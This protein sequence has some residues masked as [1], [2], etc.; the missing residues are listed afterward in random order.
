M[1]NLNSRQKDLIKIMI[2]EA[3]YKTMKYYSAYIKVSPRTLFS[4]VEIINNYLKDFNLLVEKKPRVGIKLIGDIES[5]LKVIEDLNNNFKSTKA[6]S[7]E[8]RQLEIL[9]M[10]LVEEK[11]ISYQKLSEYFWVSKTSISKDIESIESLFNDKTIAI[12]SDKKGTRIIGSEVQKQ[13]SL[14]LYTEDLLNKKSVE[15]EKDFLKYAP[16]ILKQIYP[17]ELVN[18]IF[19]EVANLEKTLNISLTYYYLRSLI[20]TLII[21]I[22][23]LGKNHHIEF[24]KN[25]IFEEI[26]SLETYFIAKNILENISNRLKIKINN[27]DVDYLNKQLIAHCIK[28][29]FSNVEQSEKYENVVKEIILEMSQIMNVNLSGDKKLY[30]GLLFHIVPMVYRLH[31]GIMIEN[32]LLKEIKEQYSVTFSATWYVMSKISDKLNIFLTCAF[33]SI[34]A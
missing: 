14:K 31:I 33:L 4:D 26:K 2:N 16:K 19:E 8:E 15:N 11:T 1:L 12:E 32:P 28:P 25:F 6:Y 21:F 30:E 3:D 7:T 34:A 13:Y 22:F 10:L 9:K 23:R 27:S 5:M 17:E 18:I 24:K 29:E 20:I